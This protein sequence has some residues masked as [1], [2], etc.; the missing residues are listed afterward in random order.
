M[1]PHCVDSCVVVIL[2][3]V[4]NWGTA[5]AEIE[6]NPVGSRDISKVLS[7]Q[8]GVGIYITLRN[9]LCLLPGPL[10]Y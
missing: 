4:Q 8:P 6:N 9:M 5:D 1:D 3:Q 7:F 2:P 10:A